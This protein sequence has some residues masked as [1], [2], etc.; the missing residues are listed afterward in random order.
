MRKTWTIG[1]VVLIALLA[2]A[3][4]FWFVVRPRF[5]ARS[6]GDTVAATT[7][8]VARGPIEQNVSAT[9]NV[10]SERRA[11]LSFSSGAPVAG[12]SVVEGQA[13]QAGDELA[14]LDTSS[15]EWQVARAEAS[16]ETAQAR[17]QQAQ[18]PASAED[19][20]SAQAGLASAQAAYDRVAAGPLPEELAYARAAYDSARANY[21]R[22][23]AGPTSAD[24][25]AA[26]A[27][28]LNAE[29]SLRQAQAAYDQVKNLPNVGAL[30]QSL[31]LQTATNQYNQAKANY[32]S[33]ANHPTPSELASAYA[34][35]L[36][37]ES[38]LAQLR[39]RPTASD[40]ATAAAQV[41]QAEA[42][43]AQLRVL[44]N[45]DALA[46]AQAQLA[47]AQ[48][49]LEQA[50]SQLDE[51]VLRAPFDGVVIDVNVSPDQWVS[52]GSPAVVVDSAGGLILDTSIDEVDVSE[53]AEGQPAYLRFTA[54]PG[55]V[56]TGTVDY[57]A[58]AATNIGGA[59]AYDV[60][61]GF[62]PGD[63]PIR[64]GMTAD[65]QVVVARDG[66]ALLVPNRAVTADREAG[67]YYV[68]RK[69]ASGLTEQVEVRIGL[70][71]SSQVQI[72]EGVSAGD[73]LVMPE[74]PGTTSGSSS[75]GPFSQMRPGGSAH[76]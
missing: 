50:R 38:T 67:R 35:M 54:L 3:A 57:I 40:L 5:Q 33:V 41:A 22:V 51:A 42:A 8:T 68:T 19:L 46:V 23:R 21:E 56:L 24:L 14:R 76:P 45:A 63:L 34:Q 74:I 15:L 49:S 75:G 18:R 37:A 53:L 6:A 31:N 44:P 20:A 48:V 64:L 1:G 71:D 9:G 62:Q 11:S 66:S 47:E 4:L 12:V 16:L 10:A 72:L 65:V 73:I 25:A 70:R 17:F 52:P 30:P 26:Q 13:V 61:I 2:V 36:Q 29:A 39:A 55:E 43:L 7:V 59:Q 58:P 28:L 27:A 69:L 32:D 60:Q